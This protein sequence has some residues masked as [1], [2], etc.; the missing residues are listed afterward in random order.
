MFVVGEQLKEL[1]D[2]AH[3]AADSAL[4]RAYGYGLSPDPSSFGYIAN[5]YSSSFVLNAAL[6]GCEDLEN[7]AAFAHRGW[8]QAHYDHPQKDASQEKLDARNQL[9]D[10]PYLNL[11]EEEKEKDRV[12]AKAV[13]ACTPRANQYYLWSDPSSEAGTCYTLCTRFELLVAC[14]WNINKVEDFLVTNFASYLTVEQADS[15]LAALA[16]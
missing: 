15:L 11:S 6:N 3:Q 8:G 12:V 2:V 13:Y 10:T 7:L 16:V 14:D 4:D 9:A 5:R 1:G